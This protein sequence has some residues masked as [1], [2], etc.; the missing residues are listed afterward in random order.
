MKTEVLKSTK[1]KKGLRALLFHGGRHVPLLWLC[2]FYL[3]ISTLLR[4]VL[5]SVFGP[6]AH[7][8]LLHLPA[9]LGLGFVNDFM[10]LSYLLL[11]FSLYLLIVPERIYGSRFGRMV[12][13]MFMG[14]LVF[15]LLYLCAVQYFFFDEFAARFNL[16][17]VDYLI[18][19]H[20]VLIN[21]WESYPVGRVLGLMAVF[22]VLLM[23]FLWPIIRRSMLVETTFRQ[24]L[25][26]IFIPNLILL[27]VAFFGFSTH[28]FS[29][30]TNRIANELTANGIS[31][32]FLA[33][34]TNQLD[35]D[36]FYRT[37]DSDEMFTLLRKQ[38]G[39]GGGEFVSG[40]LRNIN[41]RFP[42]NPKGFGKL[43]VVVIV[44]ESLGCE[45]VS[46]CGQGLDI[47]A[48][49]AQEGL[50]WTPFLNDFSRKGLFFNRAYATGT[51]TV[52][53]LEAISAS[54]PPIPSES[55][56]KRPGSENIATWGKV[57]RDNGY[58]SSFL[59]GGYGQFDN[60]NTYF[61][62]NGFDVSDRLDI[63][64]PVFTNIWGV[65]DQDLFR[66][67]QEYFDRL[68]EQKKPF[69]SIIMT[70]SNHSPFTFPPGIPGIPA[71][72]GGRNVGVLY[73][74]Y[75]LRD[76]FNEAPKHQWYKDTLFVVVADHGVR[77][78]GEAQVPLP[79]YEIPLFIFAPGR[80]V[81]QQIKTPISQM[82]IAPTVLGLL[83]FSYEAPFFGQDVLAK[84]TLPPI[85]LFNHNHDV[86]LFQKDTLEV[87]GLLNEVNSYRY[88]LGD[89][90]LES[91]PEDKRLVDLAT[92]YYQCAFELFKEKLY[93]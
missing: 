7:V 57:M 12:M 24:R 58:N 38:L 16:V 9:I 71:T 80:I 78:Y 36:Q 46:V 28:S 39:A 11:A 53:G 33:F 31:S 23:L 64:D 49:L 5:F 73:A 90:L 45:L 18:Y 91:I 50:K 60:M 43:N 32:F 76:F 21:I 27:V 14:L 20:E 81:P 48:A 74:D 85:L 89:S 42:G 79:S 52:R 75:A 87:L 63:K 68:A 62:G 19:P 83:G 22:T 86:A 29:F 6:S 41:R 1:E 77:V 26:R 59:Y 3:S 61:S 37:G 51:R 72:G 13:A 69:F 17:A 25:R 2:V 82:D 88:R 55:V 56:V 10:E 15:G 67:S 65:S 8:S 40:D 70:T 30:F 4:L 93:K 92:A 35:Y 44:E 54:F 66:H 34:R 47:D 84:S